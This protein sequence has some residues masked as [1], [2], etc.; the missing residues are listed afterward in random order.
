MKN[1][2]WFL[3]VISLVTACSSR[4]ASVGKI[5]EEIP[6]IAGT[7]YENGDSSLACYV[8]QNETSL[9]F[10]SGKQTSNGN[11]KSSYEVFAKDWNANAIL[12]TDHQT[13]SW[14]DRKWVKTTFR[15]PDI[16]GNWYEDGDASKKIIITQN[17][18]KMV[19][20]NGSQKLNGYFYTTNALYVLE[21]NNYAIYSPQKNSITWGSKS[22]VRT[23]VR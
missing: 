3:L 10:L 19:M 21:N 23:P 7:W 22:W 18:T 17:G 2:F 12:S 14:K 4:K 1:I 9:V 11:L 13:L 6:D 5:K 8:V 20:D 15:Y 16:S